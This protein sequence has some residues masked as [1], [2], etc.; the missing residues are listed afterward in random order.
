MALKLLTFDIEDWFHIIGSSANSEQSRWELF[1]AR[2]EPIL[3]RILQLLSENEQR[4]TFYIL[5]WYVKRSP[6][7]FEKILAGGHELGSHT[8]RHLPLTQMKEKDLVSEVE[9]SIKTLQDGTG[10]EV[11][12]FRAPG[13][14]IPTNKALF[15]ETL[16]RCGVRSDSSV[17]YGRH[18]VGTETVKEH[19]GQFA[20][21]TKHGTVTEF[22]VYAGRKSV[23]FPYCLGGGYLRLAPEAMC[24]RVLEWSDYAVV[25]LHPRDFDVGQPRLPDVR[26]LAR[27]KSYV[28]LQS[29]WGKLESM[30]RNTSF[31]TAI[32][33][34]E[35]DKEKAPL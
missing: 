5:S 3:D 4:A 14:S 20:I 35:L 1:D 23:V 9:N 12:S 27:F 26:G 30:L 21:E 17:F 11:T 8:D 22:P 7:I 10:S 25:Y 34:V 29:T 16:A 32:Q 18:R 33:C 6:W 19:D 28:G 31:K 13:F 2:F 15:Y 24:N